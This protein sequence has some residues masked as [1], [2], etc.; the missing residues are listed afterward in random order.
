MKLIFSYYNA[1]YLLY[2]G[3]LDRCTRESSRNGGGRIMMAENQT[4]VAL[5]AAY[6][7]ELVSPTTTTKIRSN[8]TQFLQRMVVMTYLQERCSSDIEA[9]ETLAMLER[10]CDG[11]ADAARVLR[12]EFVVSALEAVDPLKTDLSNT[13][14]T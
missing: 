9:H 14:L 2:S 7:T 8:R 1:G 11:V 5:S 13:N 6:R 12:Q 3:K 4:I 10:R